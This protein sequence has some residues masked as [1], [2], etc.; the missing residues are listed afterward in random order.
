MMDGIVNQGIIMLEGGAD[1]MLGQQRPNHILQHTLSLLGPDGKIGGV[2]RKVFLQTFG[3]IVV[4]KKQDRTGTGSKRLD[5]SLGFGELFRCRYT[6]QSLCRE[7][8]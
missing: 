1:F 5:F 2:K 7:L 4:N 3:D 6:A 8:P